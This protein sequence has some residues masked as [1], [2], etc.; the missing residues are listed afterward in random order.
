[1][2]SKSVTKLVE[3]CAPNTAYKYAPTAGKGLYSPLARAEFIHLLQEP[4]HAQG[5]GYLRALPKRDQGRPL[6]TDLLSSDKLITIQLRMD[7]SDAMTIYRTFVIWTLSLSFT[8]GMMSHLQRYNTSD[9]LRILCGTVHLFILVDT[10]FRVQ[11]SLEQL[12]RAVKDGDWPG[13]ARTASIMLT[14]LLMGLLCFIPT[15]NKYDL[16]LTLVLT[17]SLC[18]LAPDIWALILDDHLPAIR[19]ELDML[20]TLGMKICLTCQYCVSRTRR[21]YSIIEEAVNTD[22][23]EDCQKAA[24]VLYITESRSLNTCKV[25]VEQIT[26]HTWEWWPLSPSSHKLRSS[27]ARVKWYCVRIW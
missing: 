23:I 26:G 18:Y 1:M 22:V 16:A 21:L 15:L 25:A 5:S 24:R 20:F 17:V 9:L 7:M 14:A 19:L 3:H 27:Q 4:S 10:S 6:T 11:T 8:A 12:A 13:P 2:R